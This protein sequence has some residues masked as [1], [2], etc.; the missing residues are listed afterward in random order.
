MDFK[1]SKPDVRIMALQIV[2]VG[3]LAFSFQ[4]EL[5]VS[6]LFL[7][8]DLLL[9]YWYGIAF[10]LKCL[11]TYAIMRSIVLAFTMMY[12]PVLSEMIPPF[13]LLIIR[14]YPTGLLMKLLIDKAPMN[15]LLY[16]LD[17]MHVPKALS[18]PFMVVYR[19]VPTL[20]WELHHINESLKMRGLNLSLSNLKRPLKT[21]ENYM[22][23]L[24]F[25]SEKIAEELSAASLCKGLSISR[26]RTCCTAVRFTVTDGFY[27]IGMMVVIGGLFLLDTL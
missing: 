21:I 19:Y 17:K 15:E 22:V 7:I 2:I 5:P 26:K 14:I 11:I 20:L 25:R 23:P 24:L 4:N 16:I 18:I 13:L 10:F 6:A 3:V 9:L 1:A 12:L 27:L 8:V